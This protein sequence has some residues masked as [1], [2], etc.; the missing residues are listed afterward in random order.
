MGSGLYV[1]LRCGKVKQSAET[2]LHNHNLRTSETKKESNVD[3]ARSHLNK[4]ILGR[5][6]T[7][8]AINERVTEKVT[9]KVRDDANRI[10]EYVISASPEYFYDFKK[11]GITRNQWDAL[12]PTNDPEYHKK[13]KY[14][15]QTL[16]QKKLDDFTEKVK[17]FCKEEFGD[18]LINCVLH[19]DEKT[20]HFH[21]AVTPIIGNSLTAKKYFT[22]QTARSWQD[23]F[24][25]KCKPLGL[26]RGE[27]SDKKHQDLQAHRL[28]QAEKRGYRKGYRNGH[29]EGYGAG[30][31]EGSN[32]GYKEGRSEGYNEGYAEALS[33]SNRFANKAQNFFKSGQLELKDQQIEN[34]E[35]K[36][37]KE[38]DNRKEAVEDRQRVIAQNKELTR[39]LNK[40]EPGQK[41]TP[42]TVRPSQIPTP[43][44]APEPQPVHAMTPVASAPN[45]ESVGG[46]EASLNEALS[47]LKEAEAKHGPSSPQAV[48]ARIA[49]Q[50]AKDALNR[51][52][53]KTAPKV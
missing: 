26:Q 20:P 31:N 28:E 34:L 12:T 47:N 21:I 38:T 32:E 43:Q 24:A 45:A 8:K 13:V 16:D 25:E 15:F 10:L 29:K 22:P 48:Q 23:K 11:L 40:Y 18:N 50:R 5:A 9:R 17:E 49:V 7:V 42:S 37:S 44:S 2:A 27:P 33:D 52:K 35:K 1:S 19:L 53:E 41:P 36:L 39:R 30:L 4:L 3:Y 14:V 51:A 6:D 46:A